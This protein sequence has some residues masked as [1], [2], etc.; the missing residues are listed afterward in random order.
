MSCVPTTAVS[1]QGTR[2]RARLRAT[3]ALLAFALWTLAPFELREADWSDLLAVAVDDLVGN[4]LVTVPIGWLLA[5]AFGPRRAV[6]VMALASLAV[7]GSQLVL[8]SRDAALSDVVANAAGAAIGARWWR[9]PHPPATADA[10]FVAVACWAV[11]MRYGAP[12]RPTVTVALLLAWGIATLR[13]EPADSADVAGY[14]LVASS[15]FLGLSPVRL[16][17]AAFIGLAVGV[18][19]PRSMRRGRPVLGPLAVLAYLVE[20]W[21]PLRVAASRAADPALMVAELVLLVAAAG[22]LMAPGSSSPSGSDSPE[23]S[24]EPSPSRSRSDPP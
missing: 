1:P 18:L 2:G 20:C 22:L 23:P 6:A 21:P 24:S 5:A 15:G 10:M 7:E 17:T 12:N 3:L 14:A 4:L 19:L 8:V 13:E 11:A 16:V 9:R